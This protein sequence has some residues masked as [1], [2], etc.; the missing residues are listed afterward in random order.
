MMVI[1]VL[2]CI[3]LCQTRLRHNHILLKLDFI[4]PDWKS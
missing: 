4:V 2:A 3:G 1:V